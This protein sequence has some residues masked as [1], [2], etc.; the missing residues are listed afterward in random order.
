MA[1]TL[2]TVDSKQDRNQQ[3]VLM[4]LSGTLGPTYGTA[5][6]RP[7]TLTDNGYINVNAVVSA[8]DTPGG[9]IDEVTLLKAGT[10]TRVEGGSIIV[11]AGTVTTTLALNTGT[12]TTI[13]A[14]TQNT[15]GTVGTVPGVG[16]VT[17]VTNL[18]NGTIQSSGTTT[19]VGVVTSVTNLAAGTIT[20]LEQGSI[21]VTAG[22]I[23]S[24]G[25]VPGVGV[26]TSVTNLVNG[27]LGI[28]TNGTL[29]SSGT[30]TGVGVVTSVTNLVSGTLL[31]SGTTTG[32]GVVTSVT[33]L[34]AGTVTRLE[35][36]SIQITAGTI[37]A[38][39][40]TAAT[41]TAGTID[42]LKVATITVLPNL[43]QGSIN[44][45]AGTMI[46]TNGTVGAGT[47]QLNPVPVPA[48]STY[49]TLGT[50]GG[51][52]FGTLSGT[53]G[54]GTKHYVSGVSI[55]VQSGT[56]DVRVLAGSVIQGTGVLA[57]GQF[58]PGGGIARDFNPAFATGTQSELIYH[59][60]GAGTAFITVQYWKGA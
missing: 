58:P 2:G 44:V 59:F 56:P 4:G 52:F 60:V 16:V 21:Q 49:G 37:A 32:V 13:A 38:H 7:V 10:I 25:T 26:V 20:K 9:T 24:V 19:G 43:P 55:V 48:M 41:I 28:L 39:A 6:P 18:S 33:N 22:T 53:S 45:T 57:A 12:L 46:M 15:L 35:Q 50:A 27:T 5:E 47:I 40:V 8:G 36:G 3:Y 30:T 51:S 14:G 34:A 54:A 23:A 42:V 11:T 31:S 29:S 17:T 1:N